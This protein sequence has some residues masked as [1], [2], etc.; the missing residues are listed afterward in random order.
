MKNVLIVEDTP[1][2]L[3]S[4]VDLL[5]KYSSQFNT[6][7]AENGEEAINTLSKVPISVLVTDLY[8]PKV[9]GLELLSYMSRHHPD[10]PCIVMTAFSSPEI[11]GILGNLGIYRFLEKPFDSE[12][13]IKAITDAIDQINKGKSIKRLSITAFLSLL[14]EEQR[15]CTLETINQEGLKGSFYLMDGRLYD[16]KCGNLQGEEA[17]ISILGWE[18]VS[19]NLKALPPEEIKARIPISLKALIT[20]ATRPANEDKIIDKNKQKEVSASENLPEVLFQAI[21]SA[22]SGKTKLAQ[23]ALAKVL[24]INPKNSKAWLWYARTV[25]NFK[26]FNIALKNASIIS[27]NDYEISRELQKATS[28][29]NS[30]C[31]ESSTIKPCLFCWA[32]VRKEDTVCHFC[33]AHMDIKEDFFHTM[34]FDTKKE[35]EQKI[36]L[37]S[38]QRYTKATILDQENATA[39]FCLAMAHINLNQW[40]E[41]LE[42]LKKTADIAPTN[43]PYQMQLDILSDFMEDLD[44]FFT[45][46]DS[47]E[48]TPATL[49]E[50]KEQDKTIMV[51]E[52]SATTRTIIKRMLEAE[53]YTVLEARDGLEAISKFNEKT[54]DLIL[55]DIIMPGMD[56]YQT[57]ATLKKEHNLNNIPV[58]MLTAKDSLIDK[59]KGKMSGSTE[60]LTKP[61]NALDLMKKICEHLN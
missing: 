27:P 39:H 60:Y 17:A 50:P 54:P 23:Q 12:D 45:N 4:L 40:D 42:E 58:I 11:M 59:L 55:L 5:K 22:E 29:A 15:S 53:G 51:V 16:A 61:F 56:G 37:E 31:E 20:K 6:L 26:A 13:L 33:N 43:N 24:K 32:P 3:K 49:A 10:T 47:K 36:I 19:F 38:F 8:M 28:A 44:T 18:K 30:G 1:G 41:A 35:Q 21:R 57:L 9:D 14:E 48:E 46:D 25:D 34:F 7:T 52:D 2:L